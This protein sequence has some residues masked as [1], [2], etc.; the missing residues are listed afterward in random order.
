VDLR[1]VALLARFRL[2]TGARLVRAP[3]ELWELIEL[4]GLRDAIGQAE[5]GEQPRRVEEEGQ[6]PDMTA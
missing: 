2:A 1:V 5:Q 3:G 4:C 6:L